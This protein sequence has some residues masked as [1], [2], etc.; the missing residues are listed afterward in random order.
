MIGVIADDLT[1]AAELGAIG[2]HHG[3]R[4]ELISTAPCPVDADLVC[5]NIDSR[6]LSPEG[7]AARAAQATEILRQAGARWI[8]KKVDSVLRGH[9]I[10]ETQAMV[11]RL[12]LDSALIVAANPG[13]GR[14]IRQG[15]Y[16][17]GGRPIHETEFGRDPEYPRKSS[18]VTELLDDPD[19]G[20]VKVCAAGS[21]LP[22][23]GIVM[24]EAGSADDLQAWAGKR[25][26]SILLGGAAEFFE[27]LLE[28]D[29][30][31]TSVKLGESISQ[32]LAGAELFVCGTRS[33]SAGRFLQAAQRLGVPVFTW[34][35]PASGE[36]RAVELSHC[37]VEALRSNSRAVL[38]SYFASAP[39][40]A[41]AGGIARQLSRLAFVVLEHS[42][43]GHVYAEGGATASCLL[44]ELGWN[45]LS[46]IGEAAPGVVTLQPLGRQGP[47]IT[48]KPG[49]YVWPEVIQRRLARGFETTRSAQSVT[50]KSETPSG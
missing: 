8:Y 19:D 27:A 20:G 29:G 45:R 11:E 42:A 4:S 35:E 25:S 41:E 33:E 22:P 40:A 36:R 39:S 16:L 18:K 34:P 30:G 2:W 47:R 43:P 9:V 32:D 50:C 49:S 10:A 48:V 13:R 46:V 21:T 38:T 3:L 14:V 26:T 5:L 7:A 44:R 12:G 1:G 15:E 17:V 24:G 31:V 37:I 6:S 23:Q 28:A